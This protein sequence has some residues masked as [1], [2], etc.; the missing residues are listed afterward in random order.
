MSSALASVWPAVESRLDRFLRGRGVDAP[1]REDIAQETFIRALAAG[2]RFDSA[3]DL[4]S[5]VLTVARNLAVSAHRKNQRSVLGLVPD[6]PGPSDVGHMV[7]VREHFE[8]AC[9]VLRSLSPLDQRAL[10]LP[11]LDEAPLSS[12]EGNYWAVRRRRARAR[13]SERLEQVSAAVLLLRCRWRSGIGR[14]VPGAAAAATAALMW[15]PAAHHPRSA[16]SNG[17]EVT[18][19]VPTLGFLAGTGEDGNTVVAASSLLRTTPDTGGTATRLHRDAE[20]S[21]GAPTRYV[22]IEVPM[23]DGGQGTSTVVERGREGKEHLLCLGNMPVVGT[24]CAG[25]PPS[26]LLR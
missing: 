7:E 21:G 15:A 13:F 10:V 1:T 25:D 22:A 17:T 18:Q 16:P 6:R 5:W 11:L 3:D 8:L 14:V 24:V 20:G 4:S 19:L 9:R 2:L 12:H 26:S 23:P